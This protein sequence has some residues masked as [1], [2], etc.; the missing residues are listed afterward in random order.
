[1]TEE[2]KEKEA[3][4]SERDKHFVLCMLSCLCLKGCLTADVCVTNTEQI[5]QGKTF[6]HRSLH[7]IHRNNIKTLC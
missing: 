4:G 3:A 5:Y 2:E 7:L 1:M 6:L